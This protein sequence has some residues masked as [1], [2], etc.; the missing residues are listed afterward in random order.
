MELRDTS[1]NPAAH[2]NVVFLCSDFGSTVSDDYSEFC[3][4]C[5]RRHIDLM[6]SSPAGTVKPLRFVSFISA[7]AESWTN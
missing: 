4:Q 5:C 3:L 1:S 7:V 6:G 2:Q